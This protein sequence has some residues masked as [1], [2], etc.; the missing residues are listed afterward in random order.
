[1]PRSRRSSARVK[2]LHLDAPSAIDLGLAFVM[3]CLVAALI[4]A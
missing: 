1:M 2:A 3:A 4:G